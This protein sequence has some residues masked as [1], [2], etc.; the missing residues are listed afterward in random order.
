MFR[1]ILIVLLTPLVCLPMI[2]V[3]QDS[4]SYCGY[5]LIIMAVYW[6]MEAMPIPVTALLPLVLFPLMGIMK[7]EDVSLMYMKDTNVLFIGGLMMAIAIEQWNLHRRIALAVLM[8][9]GSKPR[10][11]MLGF[12]CVTA[13]LSM[14]ISNTA[15]TAMMLPIAQAVLV[16][17]SDRLEEKKAED[18][19]APST[20]GTKKKRAN[21]D[22]PDYAIQG[23][24]ADIPYVVT[25]NNDGIEYA[26]DD[27]QSNH[28]SAY[29][30]QD[31]SQVLAEEVVVVEHENAFE[32]D[33]DYRLMSKAFMLCVAYSANIGGT[34]SLIG[35]TPNLVLVGVLDD[36]Y[37]AENH[38]INFLSFM[39]YSLPAAIIFLFAAWV[40]LMCVYLDFNPKNW[41]IDGKCCCLSCSCKCNKTEEEKIVEK[42][43][44]EE[45][46]KLGDWTYAEITVLVHFVCLA[47][48]WIFRDISGFGWGNLF[49]E[50]YVTDSTPAITIAV[51]L[52]CVPSACPSFFCCRPV[53][54]DDPP[55]SKP[56]ILNWPA[57]HKNLPWGLVLLLGGGYALA[58]G[59]EVSGLSQWIGEQLAVLDYLEDWVIVLVCTTVV[60]FF[61]EVTSNT[62]IAT[63]FLPILASLAEQICMNPLYLLMPC[64]IVV[65]YAFMLPVATPPNAIAFSYGQLTIPDMA[66]VGFM[67]N[68]VGIIWVNVWVNTYGVG[69]F[70]LDEYPEWAMYENATCLDN[71]TTTMAPFTTLA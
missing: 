68:C 33:E 11:L 52:F 53:E 60:C 17:L 8:V 59:C 24:D 32:V 30:K 15:T 26:V 58:E 29:S 37:G 57:V 43:I 40:W 12:M 51:V 6:V 69:V 19:S 9:C 21:D 62:A 5:I 25:R 31:E 48:L 34:A 49:P 55:G 63:I 61:T 47:L 28:V 18:A 4:V 56:S 46:V 54:D 70:D 65:T 2:I 3:L 41:W 66:S 7:A 14:W 45:Y 67:L 64:T 27:I 20:P 71:V 50:G 13:F 39:V 10:W 16:T 44:K 1:D 38:P 35:T 22:F 42:V 36:R 23:H